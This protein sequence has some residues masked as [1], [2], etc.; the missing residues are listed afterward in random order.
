LVDPPG[1]EG[2]VEPTAAPDAVSQPLRVGILGA[3]RRGTALAHAAARLPGISI[4]AVGDVDPSRA[5]ALAERWGAIA[6]GS[7]Q[8]MLTFETL[9]A[10]F[11][12]SPSSVHAEQTLT[13]LSQGMHVYVEKPPALDLAL[14]ERIGVAADAAGKLVHV[15][16]QHRY[17]G[18][19]APWRRALAGRAISLV[20]AHLYRGLPESAGGQDPELGG[21]QLM[22]EGIHLLDLC[23]WLIGEVAAAAAHY[24]RALWAGRQ[25]GPLADS[26]AVALQFTGGAAGT[27]CTT[28][29]MPLP[30]PGHLALDV[31]AAGPLLLRYTGSALQV[32]Q[33]SGVETWTLDEPPDFAAVA[34]FLDAVRTGH[35]SALQVP[36]QDAVRTLRLALACHQ[37]AASGQVVRL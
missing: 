11:I 30:I 21:G 6:Y 17:S 28:Y 2:H 37:S 13:A 3:G 8:S 9:A 5:R 34:A 31:I 23:R 25:D 14:A 26:T 10:V 33:E 15:G 16:L 22:D 4:A 19:I 20:H 1:H 24:G 35:R 29:A 7:W 12:A 27:L 32:V 36:Y 18:L